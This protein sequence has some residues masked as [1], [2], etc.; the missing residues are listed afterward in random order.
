MKELIVAFVK[1]CLLAT[2]ILTTTGV[3]AEETKGAAPQE[4]TEAAKVA[5]K[6][7]INTAS[8]EELTTLPRI[9]PKIAERII[10]FRG[11]HE[12]FKKVEEIMNVKGIGAKTYEKLAPLISL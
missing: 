12:G 2:L 6:V 11:E 9:G 3:M 1:T 10:A 7:N 8:L 4:Q 5:G